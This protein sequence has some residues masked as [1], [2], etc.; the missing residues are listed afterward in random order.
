MN[1]LMALLMSMMTG[2]GNA[3]TGGSW[4]VTNFLNNLN[5]QLFDWGKVLV[6]IIGVVM[7]IVAVFKIGKGLMSG[8]RAQTNWVL[9]LLLFFVG[10]ALAFS[11]GWS[12][13][14]KISDGGTSTLN[15][16]GTMLPLWK[17]Y[18]GM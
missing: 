16:L 5:T 10:G 3:P 17:S 14:Q 9:N 8:G 18:L 4:S 6:V 2:G 7:V 15:D 1:T 13:V 11:G 12:L